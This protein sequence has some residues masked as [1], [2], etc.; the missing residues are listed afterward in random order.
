MPAINLMD[1]CG[2][3][4][5]GQTVFSEGRYSCLLLKGHEHTQVFQGMP[6]HAG[7]AEAAP[8]YDRYE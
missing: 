6:G 3:P 5:P 1:L 7:K 8:A 2:G 4:E